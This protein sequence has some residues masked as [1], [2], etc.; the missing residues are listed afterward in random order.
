MNIPQSGTMNLATELFFPSPSLPPK[1]FVKAEMEICI[2]P[3]A[4][5]HYAA[6]NTETVF[7]IF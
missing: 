4:V 5:M 1:S 2:Q 3:A 7:L 6:V